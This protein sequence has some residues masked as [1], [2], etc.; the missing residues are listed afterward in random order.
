MSDS[1]PLIQMEGEA[2][3]AAAAVYHMKGRASVKIEFLLFHV[4]TKP[5]LLLAADAR[6]HE[7]NEE[8]LPFLCPR[9]GWER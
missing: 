1:S 9:Q 3:P 6:S 5:F 8:P 4:R 2:S 7:S